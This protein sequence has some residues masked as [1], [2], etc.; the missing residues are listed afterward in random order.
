MNLR[1]AMGGVIVCARRRQAMRAT[2]AEAL[3]TALKSG[4]KERS[5]TLRLVNAAIQD[6]DIANRG[7]GKGAATDD[8]VI[9]ILAKMVKQREESAK[10][11]DDG[12][13]P[14]LAAKERAEIEIIRA[15]LP[16]QMDDAAMQQAIT[17]AIS[18]I[19]AANVRDMGR[20]MAAL[21]EKYAGQ[22]DFGKASGVV[23]SLLQ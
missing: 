7:A 8:E 6:R 16:K 4:D 10:A 1:R 2:I 18:E 9:Q 3:K 5:G 11:F 15:F 23:K 19:G 17:D 13:R 12:K 14:E 22:M 20:V 21:R